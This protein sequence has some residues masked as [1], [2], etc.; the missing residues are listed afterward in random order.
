MSSIILACITLKR[1]SVIHIFGTAVVAD[2]SLDHDSAGVHPGVGC[3]RAIALELC[4][5][6]IVRPGLVFTKYQ[7]SGSS[8]QKGHL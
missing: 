2:F 6:V 5:C 4:M 3:T 1:S 7:L 8:N